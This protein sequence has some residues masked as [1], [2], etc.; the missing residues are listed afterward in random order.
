M[1]VSD[2]SVV[3]CM[4]IFRVFIPFKYAIDIRTANFL[5]KCIDSDKTLCKTLAR[6]RRLQLNNLCQKYVCDKFLNSK[7][8]GIQLFPIGYFNVHYPLQ[9]NLP[10]F[11]YIMLFSVVYSSLCVSS[12]YTIYVCIVYYRRVTFNTNYVNRPQQQTITINHSL[13]RYFDAAKN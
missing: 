9:A 4:Y 13:N 3:I 11:C 10:S 12:Q 6:R 8:C 2:N 7:H 5:A 1:S